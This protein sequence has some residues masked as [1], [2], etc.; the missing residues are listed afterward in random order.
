MNRTV[1]GLLAAF[2]LALG[3]PGA[4]LAEG[5]DAPKPAANPALLAPSLATEQAPDAFRV[6]FDTTKGKIVIDVKREWSPNGADR[7]YNLV[8]IGFY[9]DIAFFRVIPG[10][11]AQFGIN[12]DPAVSKIWK[13]ATITDDPVVQSNARGFITYAKTRAPNSRTTQLFINLKDNKALDRQGFAPFGQVVEGMDVVDAIF[14]IGEGAPRGKGPAQGRIQSQGNDYLKKSFSSLDYI[15]SA[16][17]LPEA[18][19]G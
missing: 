10:F 2:L 15:T 4:L 12:G 8:K 7:F 17:I 6:Q 14:K 11:M 19:D 18:S 5:E 9:E 16:K 1:M 3:L 13:Q